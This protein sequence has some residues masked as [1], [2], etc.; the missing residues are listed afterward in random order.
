MQV[1]LCW[2]LYLEVQ[3]SKI[4]PRGKSISPDP[5]TTFVEGSSISQI[6]LFKNQFSSL[7]LSS[8]DKIS[9]HLYGLAYFKLKEMQ[10]SSTV[11]AFFG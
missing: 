4:F 1:T 2:Q 8:K 6:T 7:P 3:I 10:L 5:Y 11:T 9:Y